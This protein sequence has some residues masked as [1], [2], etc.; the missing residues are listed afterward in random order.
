MKVD[1]G[2]GENVQI[3]MRR[4]LKVELLVIL[5]CNGQIEREWQV[6]RLKN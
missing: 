6:K 2:E 3:Y 5:I 4:E 1:K